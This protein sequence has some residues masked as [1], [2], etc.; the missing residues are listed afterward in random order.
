VAIKWSALKVSEAMD[1]AGGFIKE[2][3]TPLGLAKLVVTEA[4]KIPDLPQYMDV[5]LISLISQIDRM[6]KIK[7]VL[8]SIRDDI[9]QA[10]LDEQRK[11]AEYGTQQSIL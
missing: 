5:R 9:P 8:K 11:Q 2:A 7:S 1:E 6:D 10:D 4:R 3:D